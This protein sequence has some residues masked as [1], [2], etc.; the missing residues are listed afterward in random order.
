MTDTTTDA[1]TQAGTPGAEHERLDQFI[2]TWDAQVKM[3]MGPE[4]DVDESQGTMVNSW[5]LG[6]RFLRHDYSSQWHGM[7]FEGAGYWGFNNATGKYEGLWIDTVSSTGFNLEFGDCDDAGKTWN[8]AGEVDVPGVGKM[9]KRSVVTVKDADH[10]SM[11]T[12][13]QNPDGTEF[14]AMEIQYSRK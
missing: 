9:K 14:K 11:E 4:C 12:Y 6:K 10:H 8:M 3:W 1:C 2:G 7:E 5:E 13:F